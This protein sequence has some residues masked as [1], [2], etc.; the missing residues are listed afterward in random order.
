MLDN[1]RN[2]INTLKRSI[3]KVTIKLLPVMGSLPVISVNVH[4]ALQLNIIDLHSWSAHVC[5]RPIFLDV[6]MRTKR[7]RTA[8]HNTYPPAIGDC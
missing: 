5:S 6:S 1:L 2:Q 8:R 3:L 4:R 7:T